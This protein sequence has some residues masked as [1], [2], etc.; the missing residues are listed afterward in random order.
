[1]WPFLQNTFDVIFK[2]S[3]SEQ[4]AKSADEI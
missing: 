3:S 2:P 1:M 4:A